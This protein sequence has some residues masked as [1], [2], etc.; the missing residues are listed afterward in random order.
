[1]PELIIVP[2]LF[3]TIGFI[4]WTIV[5]SVQHRHRLRML[6][7]FNNKLIDRLGSVNDFAEFAK[8]DTGTRFL[9]SVMAEAPMMRPGERIL[10]AVQIGIVL[11]VLALGLLSLGWYF[12]GNAAQEP[13]I[14]TGVLALS[15]GIGFLLSSAASHRVSTSLGLLRND[16]K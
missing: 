12:Q 4:V 9:N 6:V 8:T 15:I 11:V 13:F 3:F 10:R 14:V 2:A 16:G 5:S 1:M 7:E